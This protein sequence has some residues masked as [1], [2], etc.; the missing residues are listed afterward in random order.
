MGL[1]REA[2]GA[3]DVMAR[4]PLNLEDLLCLRRALR[5]WIVNFVNSVFVVLEYLLHLLLR[6]EAAVVPEPVVRQ[7]LAAVIAHVLL[8]V[9]S[10]DFLVP[11]LEDL[12]PA[13]FLGQSRSAHGHI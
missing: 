6:N 4:V 1:L 12:G 2:L 11:E 7:V 10:L 3:A 8:F 9:C 13:L 5:V